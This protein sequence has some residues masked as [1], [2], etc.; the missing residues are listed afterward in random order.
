MD[1]CG[2]GK[3]R[4]LV[5]GATN[6]PFDL[7]EAALRRMTKRIFIGL[8]DGEARSGQIQKLLESVACNLSK[9][10]FDRIVVLSN[11]YSSADL[12]AVVKDAAMGPL[13]DLP[14]GKTVLTVKA[15][16]LRSIRL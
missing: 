6:R 9:Q 8:P 12:A 1:G 15:E 11:G 14:P 10:D 3:G 7:D 4:V 5:I 16:E 2:S 13:R